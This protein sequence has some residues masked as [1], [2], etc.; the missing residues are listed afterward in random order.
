[1]SVSPVD[2][3]KEMLLRARAG[4]IESVAVAAVWH[5][6]STSSVFSDSSNTVLLIG[7]VECL[8]HELVVEA[9]SGLDEEDAGPPS[10][11]DPP[12]SSGTV[13]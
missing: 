3:L 9:T 1:M 5:D 11:D 8:K 7:C 12:V 2:V 6:G 4:T 13:Q 10:G